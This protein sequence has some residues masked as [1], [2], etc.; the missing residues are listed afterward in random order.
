MAEKSP[1]RMLIRVA[2]AKTVAG[3]LKNLMELYTIREW[4][5]WGEGGLKKSVTVCMLFGGANYEHNMVDERERWRENVST[6]KRN[7]WNR[8]PQGW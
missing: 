1:A 8:G 4:R 3:F 5:R 6:S 2:G 7:A